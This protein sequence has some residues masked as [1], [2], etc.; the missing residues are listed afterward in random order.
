MQ[1][2]R[3]IMLKSSFVDLTAITKPGFKIGRSLCA[4][5]VTIHAMP[6]NKVN[7]FML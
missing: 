7:L 6:A 5:M 1:W 2:S 4:N 3:F